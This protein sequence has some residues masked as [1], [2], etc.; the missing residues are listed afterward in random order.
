M[1]VQPALGCVRWL[2]RNVEV[3]TLNEEGGRSERTTGVEPL[4]GVEYTCCAKWWVGD[5]QTCG[6]P[7]GR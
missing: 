7:L 1:L 4:G 3:K 5:P 6:S 2:G